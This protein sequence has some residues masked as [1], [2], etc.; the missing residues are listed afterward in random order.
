MTCDIY[1]LDSFT[2]TLFTG[3]PAAVVPLSAWLPDHVM[4]GIALENNLPETAF[5]VPEKDGF[6][7]RWFT[8]TV[9]MNLCGHATL[10]AAWV[11]FNALG[12][13][14]EVIR[15]SSLSG[16]LFVKKNGDLMTLDFPALYSEKSAPEP[17]ITQIFGA[18]CR[19]LFKGKKWVAFYDNPDFIRRAKP[20]MDLI[21][22]TADEGLIIT[23][24]GDGKYDFISRYFAPQIGIDEDPV[25][26]AAHCR[27]APL[28]ADKLNKTVFLA[29][30]ASARGGDVACELK[31]DRVLLSGK[32]VLYL[33]GH[34]YV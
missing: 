16:D 28:W 19:E 30:Q 11:I 10:A 24:S 26:G 20:R 9:E 33:K 31:N 21:K 7:L 6:H 27:L 13:T 32:A 8:P 25:T 18:P 17:I 3:N 29:H 15:F 1:K 34:I 4:K 23:A 12:Y 5:F 14:G 2:D 22:N